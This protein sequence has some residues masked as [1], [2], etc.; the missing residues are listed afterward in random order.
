MS[1]R[2]Q[3]GQWNGW[4]HCRLTI[5]AAHTAHT[6]DGWHPGDLELVEAAIGMCGRATTAVAHFQEEPGMFRWRIER[7]AANR[8]RIR[9][10]TFRDWNPELT[11]DAGRPM[12]D[13]L[14]GAVA[15]A[16]AIHFGIQE[17][18]ESVEGDAISRDR[19]ELRSRVEV[20]G[21]RLER[22]NR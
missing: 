8:L 4:L 2:F 7:V 10:F 18:L 22:F 14:C 6:V 1:I 16:Q 21:K 17:F 12:F 11:D 9:V 20:L 5:G 13:E 15:F 19:A 3:Y